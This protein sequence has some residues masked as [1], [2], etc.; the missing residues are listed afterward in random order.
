M[1]VHRIASF[2]ALPRADETV[3]E[4]ASLVRAVL[5]FAREDGYAPVEAR[6]QVLAMLHCEFAGAVVSEFHIFDT[7]SFAD[8]SLDIEYPVGYKRTITSA[9]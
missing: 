3:G 1:N 8:W 6:R 4:I 9:H 7:L 2:D 5:G